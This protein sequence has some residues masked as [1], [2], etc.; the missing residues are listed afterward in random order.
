MS[1]PT[2]SKVTAD[3]GGFSAR[4]VGLGI[5]KEKATRHSHGGKEYLFCCQG[6]ADVFAADPEIRLQETKDLI[7]CPTCLAEKPPQ[8]AVTLEHAG[9][10]SHF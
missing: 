8:S 6:C 10:E 2:Y 4:Q 5:S 9:E 7:V 1:C 3:C